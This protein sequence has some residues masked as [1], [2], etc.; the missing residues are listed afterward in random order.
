MCS[1]VADAL[2]AYFGVCGLALMKEPGLNKMH[3][4]FNIS[5]HAAQHLVHIH[6]TWQ[7]EQQRP[8]SEFHHNQHIAFLRSS[9]RNLSLQED[10]Q[11][12][13]RFV[14]L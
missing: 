1:I 6:A 4:A 12:I 2:H 8:H 3:A 7:C 10:L 5:E 13:D 9:L 14:S 11:Q